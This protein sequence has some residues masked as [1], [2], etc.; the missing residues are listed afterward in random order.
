MV[1][2][3]TYGLKFVSISRTEYTVTRRNH[4]VS[5]TSFLLYAACLE[6]F[7]EERSFV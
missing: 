2:V 7:P 6:A 3:H 4:I 1:G 5:R